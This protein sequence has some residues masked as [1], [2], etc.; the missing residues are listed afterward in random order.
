MVTENT[1][2]LRKNKDRN[3]AIIKRIPAGEWGKNNDLK[4]ISVY[5]AS[6]A[7]NYVYGSVIPVDGGW[8]AR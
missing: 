8:L 4:G 6:D 5:L 2:A 3:Q 1:A 7:S